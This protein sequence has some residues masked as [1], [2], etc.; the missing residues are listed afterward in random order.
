VLQITAVICSLS[1]VVA[2]FR[3][4]RSFQRMESSIPQTSDMDVLVAL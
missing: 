2:S 4:K 3:K 1:I